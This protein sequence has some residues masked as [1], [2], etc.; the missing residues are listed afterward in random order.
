MPDFEDIHKQN[1]Y[2]YAKQVEDSYISF[3]KKIVSIVND[4]KA[5]LQK[6]FKFSNNKEIQ[7]RTDKLTGEFNAALYDLFYTSITKEWELAN[8]KNDILIKETI[9]SAEVLS[10]MPGLTDHNISALKSF[11]ERKENSLGLSDRVWNMA[12][13]FRDE[14]EMHLQIGIINGDPANVISRRVRENLLEPEKLFRRVRNKEGNLILSESA[15]AFH[16]GQGVYRSSFKNARRLAVTETNMA[17]RNA[18]HERWKN[19]PMVVGFEVKVSG[20]HSKDMCDPLAGK[21]PKSFHWTGWHPH[22]FCYATPI[23]LSDKEH[24]EYIDSILD[25]KEYNPRQSKEYV[26]SVPEGFKSWVEENK[27]RIESM[28]NPPLWIKD[29]K[30]L[31]GAKPIFT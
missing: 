30:I 11:I 4:P 24:D 21:Y 13:S 5:K 16:P 18:D 27:E 1:V 9:K 17:Y 12:K 7:K 8:Q 28:K 22:C 19:N 6:A 2:R 20:N 31:Q 3:A 14:L 23:Q 29:N 10:L 25:G 15:K 26:S